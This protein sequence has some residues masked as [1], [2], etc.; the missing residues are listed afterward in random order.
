MS[1]ED[2][3]RKRLA[4]A[5][6][7]Y[8]TLLSRSQDP[9]IAADHLRASVVMRDLGAVTRLAELSGELSAAEEAIA[10][11]RSLLELD[12][13]DEDT[14]ALAA[15][16]IA[17]QEA[18]FK[19]LLDEAV[20]EMLASVGPGGRSVIMEIRAGTG[21]DEAGLF[22]GDLFRMYT[23]YAERQ[24]MKWEVLSA[25]PTELKGF[26]EVVFSVKGKKAWRSLQF[27]SGGHR[28]QRVPETEAQG[29]IH[30]SLAT[31]AV[32]PEAEEVDVDV[33][34]DDLH[35]D[36]YRASGP[37]GQKVNKTSSAVRIIHLPT[38]LKVECQDEKSQHKNKARAMKILR[39]RILDHLRQKADLERSDLRRNQ[40]GS[41]DRNE[42]IRT[43]N[44]PQSR[45]TDHRINLNLYGLAGVM[46][47][48]L[49]EL[50]EKLG[51]YNREQR[52]RALA[53]EPD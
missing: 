48:D 34:K 10:E 7:R 31:V 3:V 39:S 41:G 29:R 25:I 51:E 9:E 2:A 14:I 37:G 19:A 36:F 15:S 8:E 28:V 16:E 44:F 17:D 47:G 26:K 11:A 27:E 35:I 24:R 4:H 12:P 40:I 43:Y 46:D 53:E 13:E 49:E 30:T 18:R 22:A 33:K 21:G 1:V 50:F 5:V 45:V 52:L 23:R 6:E 42:R 38:G 32:M 20:D